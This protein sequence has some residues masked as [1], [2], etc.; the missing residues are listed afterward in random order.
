[1]EDGFGLMFLPFSCAELLDCA[2]TLAPR[3]EEP[4]QILV[5]RQLTAAHQREQLVAV[6]HM[7]IYAEL[8]HLS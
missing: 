8:E 1:M 4:S 6:S 7:S 5:R 2:L 3:H